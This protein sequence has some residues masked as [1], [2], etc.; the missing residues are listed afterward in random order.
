MSHFYLTLPSN[1]STNY[2]PN[3]TLTRFITKLHNDVSLNG[4]WEVGLVDIMYP[5][6]W[7]NLEK[8]YLVVTCKDCTQSDGLDREE[9]YTDITVPIPSGFYEDISDL[10]TVLNASIYKTFNHPVVK[11]N[12]GGIYRYADKFLYPV[13]RYTL[14]DQKAHINMQ[15][16]MTVVL[17]EDLAGVLGMEIHADLSA[18]EGLNGEMFAESYKQA[19]FRDD[20]HALYVYCDV[21]ECV[22]VGDTLAPLLRIVEV[23]GSR[24][25]MVHI[26]F[27]QPRYIPIQKKCFDSIEIDIRDDT[28]DPVSF[29]TG[30]LIVTLHFRRAKDTYFL[31]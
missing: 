26:Q 27:D 13:F 2:F 20:L 25:E 12:D 1:S 15:P 3:N 31:G 29:D 21:L 9:V 23:S 19:K 10:I 16:S 17:S 22:P 18:S 24:D 5:R 4:D 11:S 6:N 8:Q 28:G 30:K 14:S 7:F